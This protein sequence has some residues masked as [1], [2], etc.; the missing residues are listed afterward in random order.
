MLIFIFQTP[1][2]YTEE[3]KQQQSIFKLFSLTVIHHPILT[4]YYE[5]AFVD[6]V[7]VRI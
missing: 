3:W 5:S 4:T 1:L 6:T 7:D 2:W